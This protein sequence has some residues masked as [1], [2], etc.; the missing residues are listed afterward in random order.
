MPSIKEARLD[1]RLEAETKE[2]IE[3]AARLARESTSAFVI[4]AAAE[5]ADHLLARADL[6]VMP[7]E[8]FDEMLAS[9][10][11]ADEVTA[12]TRLGQSERRYV[13]K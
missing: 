9:L 3:R 13:R 2:R 4:H 6:T 7:A 10:D 12:L 5:R 11:V 8:Q 1:L